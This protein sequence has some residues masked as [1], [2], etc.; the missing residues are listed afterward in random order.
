MKVGVTLQQVA[1][2]AVRDGCYPATRVAV[3]GKAVDDP[4]R[5]QQQAGRFKC[6]AFP[7]R[8]H[9]SAAFRDE[10]DMVEIAMEMRLDRPLAGA[11]AVVQAFDM[12]KALRNAALRLSIEVEAVDG[13]SHGSP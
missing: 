10:D 7:I 11:G 8:P 1:Q 2:I 12:D 13:V 4:G 6:D 5:H 3:P 9:R